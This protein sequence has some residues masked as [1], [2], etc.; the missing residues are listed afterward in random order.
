VNTGSKPLVGIVSGSPSDAEM[1]GACVD[2]LDRYG[3]PREDRIF[4]AHRQADVLRAWIRETESRGCVLF[5]ALAGMAAHLPGVVASLSARPVL[6]V[7]LPG[8]IL[9]GL[10]ALLSVVQ[11]P[12]GVPVA[13]LAVGKPGAKNAAHMAARI[14]ALSD[15]DLAGRIDEHRRD[16]AEGGR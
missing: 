3:I 14:L 15:P 9:D 1:V 5:I 6:G 2:V 8:G 4:S 13:S 11:M 12:A 7:P 10:D 16:M